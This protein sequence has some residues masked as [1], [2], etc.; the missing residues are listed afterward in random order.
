MGEVGSCTVETFVRG[1]R[2]ILVLAKLQSV[3]IIDMYIATNNFVTARFYTICYACPVDA[4]Y[5]KHHSVD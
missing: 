3:T 1:R 5:A 2:N 4:S